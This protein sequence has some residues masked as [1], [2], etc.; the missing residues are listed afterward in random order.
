[1]NARN[2][3]FP[4]PRLIVE[5]H[6]SDNNVRRDVIKGLPFTTRKE[7]H[8]ELYW[9]IS[10]QEHNFG[11][12]SHAICVMPELVI[13]SETTRDNPSRDGHLRSCSS[14]MHYLSACDE[15]IKLR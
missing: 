9:S 10:T 15:H 7:S 13:Y 12:T 3:A 11:F 14:S 6:V 5:K 2:R 1:M 8:Y 4:Q